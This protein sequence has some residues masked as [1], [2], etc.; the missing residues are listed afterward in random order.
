MTDS[1]QESENQPV[2]KTNWKKVYILVLAFF[3]LFCLFMYIFTKY[4]A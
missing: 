2:E 4:T 1:V 3:A